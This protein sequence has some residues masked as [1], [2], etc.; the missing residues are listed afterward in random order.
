MHID[1]EPD[2][3][4]NFLKQFYSF[5]YFERYLNKKYISTAF[6]KQKILIQLS[7]PIDKFIHWIYSRDSFVFSFPVDWTGEFQWIFLQNEILLSVLRPLLCSGFRFL[8]HFRWKLHIF[9]ERGLIEP[10]GFKMFIQIIFLMR[11]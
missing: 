5:F 2:K 8:V 10:E 3:G 7:D 4:F 6:P 1:K 9:Q 11:V